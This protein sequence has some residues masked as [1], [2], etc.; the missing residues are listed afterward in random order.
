MPYFRR[1][2]RMIREK[3]ITELELL[4]PAK[5]ADFGIAAIKAGADAVYIGA[6]QFGARAAAG[7]SLS[8]ITRLVEFAHQY[9]ARVYVVVNTIIYENELSQVESL[10]HSLYKIGVDAIIIQDLGILKMNIPPIPIFA[11]TQTNNYDLER[12]KFIDSLGVDRIILARELSLEQIDTIRQNTRCDLEAFI[13]GALCVS[14]SG[15]CYMSAES[16]GRSANRG[17]CSQMCR[18]QFTLKQEDGKIIEKDKYLLSLKD[19]N[20]ENYLK[21]LIKSGVTSFKIEGRLKDISYIT[22]SVAHFRLKLDDAIRLLNLKEK[23]Y[24]KQSSGE[25][26]HHFIP[27]LSRTFSRGTTNYFIDSIKLKNRKMSTFDTQKSIGKLIGTVC[28]ASGRAIIIDNSEQINNNDG[29][30]YYDEKGTLQ[31]FSVNSVSDASHSKSKGNMQDFGVNKYGKTKII[32]NKN[33][34][35]IKRGTKLYRNDDVEFEKIMKN[36]PCD[37]V[38]RVDIS[39]AEQEGKLIFTAK[40]EDGNM[41]TYSYSPATDEQRNP[42]NFDTIEKQLRKTGNTIFEVGKVTIP[43]ELKLACSIAELNQIRREL[44]DTLLEKRRENYPQLHRQNTPIKYEGKLREDEILNIANSLSKKLY[45]EVLGENLHHQ[46]APEVSKD[47]SEIPLMTTCYC[48]KR[49]LGVCPK[50]N[51]KGNKEKYLYLQDNQ[52]KY[53]V[54]FD[55]ANCRNL[56]YKQ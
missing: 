51:K 35:S 5:N 39:I 8:E 11:S 27:D 31:G 49:E 4:A 1:F 56:I 3:N 42:L 18:H 19:L 2:S 23:R 12:I 44:L 10:I 13:Y 52:N 15:Q 48:I 50:D 9:Y 45:T 37:R 20:L 36:K 28:E 53:K 47:F 16:C 30:C 38:L 32:A 26:I 29:L 22:N 25:S 33:L 55:C 43:K 41:S 24:K 14:L 6:E 7:N 54:Q 46:L 34:K 21:S 40:G 17:E